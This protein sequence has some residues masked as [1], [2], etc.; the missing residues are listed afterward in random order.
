VNARSAAPSFAG[1]FDMEAVE[2]QPLSLDLMKHDNLLGLGS[3]KLDFT[4]SGA[5]QAAIMSSIDGSGG[6]DIANGAL[7]GVNIVKLAQAADSLRTGGI[8]PAALTS[9]VAT[10]RG[11]REETDFSS[12]LSNFSIADGLVD[13]PA[14]SLDGP[15]LTMTG[16]GQI[17]L[18]AQTIDLRLAPRA[19]TSADGST[20]RALAVPV[21]VG[22]TF[23]EPTIG[24]D[25]EALAQA[26]LQNTLGGFLGGAPSSP[27]DAATKAI[28][29]LLGQPEQSN[30][31][32]EKTDASAEAAP[33]EELIRQGLGALFGRANREEEEGEEENQE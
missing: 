30:D 31:G 23:T 6:F 26:A 9:A 32:G 28:Q 16:T 22:G 11:P 15:F 18:A 17:N 4:A 2:A 25:G 27:E 12:F 8:N 5:S 13:A 33:E 24:V 14:I 19:T 29:G 7:K 10:A 21:R 1:N 3:F 20:G